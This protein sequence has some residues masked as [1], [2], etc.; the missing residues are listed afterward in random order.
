MAKRTIK[1]Y[2]KTLPRTCQLSSV[3][4]AK[5][6]LEVIQECADGKRGKYQKIYSEDKAWITQYT[7]RNGISA[8]LC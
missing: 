4:A 5:E 7:A 8:A 1:D 6:E 3:Q 2:F